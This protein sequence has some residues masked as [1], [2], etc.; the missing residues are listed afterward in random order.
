MF[1][2]I[3][4]ST[5]FS[6]SIAEELLSAKVKFINP[7]NGPVF[8]G[9]YDTSLQSTCRAILYHRI[10]EDVQLQLF[11][12]NWNGVHDLKN[13]IMN[14][15][16]KRRPV[17]LTLVKISTSS[18]MDD[19]KEAFDK[20]HDEKWKEVEK[21]RLF[22]MKHFQCYCY[23][24]EATMES[25]ILYQCRHSSLKTVFKVDLCFIILFSA[26]YSMHFHGFA[27]LTQS[28]MMKRHCC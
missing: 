7:C 8:R 9:A 6:E 17:S 13:K 27:I 5:P 22:C 4:V 26:Q 10:P 20:L 11:Y 24:R 14:V 19:V 15:F 2:N 25:V 16:D 28:Q 18:N 1:N 12:Y 23:V 21:V 3:V